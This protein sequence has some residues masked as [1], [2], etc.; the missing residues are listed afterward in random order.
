MGYENIEI[1]DLGEDR[2]IL[3]CDNSIES[4]EKNI[5]RDFF[6]DIIALEDFM[7]NFYKEIIY[8]AKTL[9]IKVY[10]KGKYWQNSEKQNIIWRVSK[11]YNYKINYVDPYSKLMTLNQKKFDCI[12]NYP[13]T[14]TYYTFQ[15]LG[16]RNLFFIPSS[17]SKIFDS[18]IKDICLGK[19]QLI[20]NLK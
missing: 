11:L 15:N 10:Y 13:F 17:Y 8:A 16:L 1:I 2:S 3:F 18:T 5:S 9:N 19:D 7:Y 6:G 12:I 20:K 4:K 14:S